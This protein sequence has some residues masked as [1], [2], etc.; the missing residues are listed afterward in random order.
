MEKPG[1]GRRCGTTAARS[2]TSAAALT[3]AMLAQ[4]VL[5]S[6]AGAASVSVDK[7]M[8]RLVIAVAPVERNTLLMSVSSDVYGVTDHGSPITARIGCRAK[9]SLRAGVSKPIEVEISRNG[10]RRVMREKKARYRISAVTRSGG[11]TTTARKTMTL[12]A[13]RAGQS[14]RWC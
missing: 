3:L 5:P 12:K 13:P 6:L 10:R 14:R 8:Y 11:R 2:L 4:T 9:F 7:E 1:L